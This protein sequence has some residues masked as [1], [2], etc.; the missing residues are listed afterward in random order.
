MHNNSDLDDITKFTYLSDSLHG[1]GRKPIDGIKITSDN[2]LTA[3][4]VLHNRFG[5][6]DMVIQNR[7]KNLLSNLTVKCN[8]TSGPKYVKA[9]WHFY[10]EVVA[11][12]RSL[13]T[14]GI[15][16]QLMS[17]FLCPMV[18]SK[19]PESIRF[20][21]F[22]T[23]DECSGSIA[24]LLQF[25]NHQFQT[26]DRTVRAGNGG[27]SISFVSD[28][29]D[30]PD[31]SVKNKNSNF[32]KNSSASA[33]A[34]LANANSNTG[35]K[36]K[37]AFCLKN[38]HGIETCIKFLKLPI[39]ERNNEV[40]SKTIC[41][42]CL[43]TSH[44]FASCNHTCSSCHGRHNHLLCKGVTSQGVQG[45]GERS[46]ACPTTSVTT[47]TTTS[48]NTVT[49]T[50]TLLQHSSSNKISVLQ[51][52]KTHIITKNQNVPVNILFDSGSDRSYIVS[53][54]ATKCK[55]KIS[56][57]EEV[58][59][60][61]FG[62][63]KSSKPR[64]SKV[65]NVNLLGSDEC[66]YS[67]SVID[68]PE[69]CK[70]LFRQKIPQVLLNKFNVENLSDDLS[71]NRKIFIHI[72]IGLDHLWDFINPLKC[73]R[74]ESLIAQE[75]V[76]GW[77]VSGSFS[78]AN[79]YANVKTQL[80]CFNVTNEDLKNLFAMDV[81]G[82]TPKENLDCIKNSPVIRTFNETLK[83]ENQKYTVN[84]LWKNPEVKIVNNLSLVIKRQIALERHFEK[85]PD[86]REKYYE[87]FNKYEVQSKIMEVPQNEIDLD[88]NINYLPHFPVVKET[89]D[90]SKVRPVFDGSAKS[91]NDKSLNDF[92]ETG[93]AL[94]LKIFSILLR[95]R[96]WLIP[97]TSDVESAFHAI[98]LN[99][100][101]QD[102][103]RFILYNRDG[104]FRHMRFVTL[105]FG[106]NCSPFLLNAV[107]SHHINKYP[108][109]LTVHEM[110]N[111]IY[112]DDF[113]SGCD[114]PETAAIIHDES[115]N[116]LAEGGFKLTKW[117]TTDKRVQKTLGFVEKEENYV[118]G[119]C[120]D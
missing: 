86:L 91:F 63:T 74:Q 13:A 49:T 3:L 93:P 97:L 22:K 45:T 94:H 2:Y 52:A 87:V 75:S 99:P 58:I 104:S 85:N 25:M 60:G 80:C 95:F 65:Y 114:K 115:K 40:R 23:H 68:I 78:N 84:L 64:L 37:C 100:I 111:N 108:N 107:I 81:I 24:D 46:S 17:T 101:D 26:L 90:T 20:E 117:N 56:G 8:V 47:V 48:A 39:I 16:R 82:V 53:D 109:N 35:E 11:H 7:I 119:M 66:K 73:V 106:L 43:K 18:L 4:E 77:V 38:G 83:F 116:I 70:P 51:T 42:K 102:V 57:M 59:F 9:L 69:I 50:S 21:W 12:M 34:L 5:R 89:R 76:F 79:S 98:N 72:L 44:N 41:S 92:L 113:I 33:S 15:Q 71:S 96:R 120:L 88:K 118:L 19:L 103:C 62:N 30:K 110:L 54:I 55:L 27:L 112:V 61:N 31:K 14:L 105:P 32:Q 36:P 10:D 67:L 6:N 28:Y 29:S 1:E